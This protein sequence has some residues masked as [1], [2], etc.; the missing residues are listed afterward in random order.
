MAKTETLTDD[1]STE[2]T[3][4][5]T[6]YGGSEFSV[7]SG[8]LHAE[9]PTRSVPLQSNSTYDLEASYA[10]IELPTR[11]DA[12]QFALYDSVAESHVISFGYDPD[13]F[14]GVFGTNLFAIDWN[15]GFATAT[16][17]ATSHRWL[18][19]RESG[20]TIYADTSEDGESWTE[21]YSTTEVTDY[22]VVNV[23]LLG[24]GAVFDNLN[25]TP[26]GGP[27]ANTSG[28]FALF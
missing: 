3:G 5:W 14:G 11:G 22:G 13:L 7:V 24:D 26:G 8:Q 4:K 21:F 25:T 2:D 10:F 12:F 19:I 1:F 20:G 15:F 18:R 9:D 23:Q 28:F 16:Y 27:P 6:G 17:N